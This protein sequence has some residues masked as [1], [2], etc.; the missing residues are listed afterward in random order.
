MYGTLGSPVAPPG[1]R[2]GSPLWVTVGLVHVLLWLN[3]IAQSAMAVQLAWDEDEGHAI[4]TATLVA[5]VATVLFA[6]F[7]ALSSTDPMGGTQAALG[8]LAWVSAATALGANILLLVQIS[9]YRNLQLAHNLTSTDAITSD[10]LYGIHSGVLS[11]AVA[12]AILSRHEMAA[13]AHKA[14][15]ANTA[16]AALYFT[17]A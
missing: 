6:V 3:V 8:Y 2:E 4:A 7:A 9:D 17:R 14:A 11:C 12:F 1:V 15:N 16:G 10:Q 13:L 5:A